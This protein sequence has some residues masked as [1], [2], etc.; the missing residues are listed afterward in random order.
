M[1][2]YPVPF[3]TKE[4]DKLLFNLS[5]KQVL[6]IGSSVLLALIMAGV[7][8]A[9]LQT[10]MLFC[11]P[12]GIPVVFIGVVMAL[13]RLNISGCEITV[14]DLLFLKYKFTQ[15]NRHYIAQR[16]AKEEAEWYF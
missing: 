14:G 12:I 15:R 13:K 5:T 6:I 3:S 9:T 2:H 7:M 1:R 11:I 10:Y 4:E 8:A 16:R